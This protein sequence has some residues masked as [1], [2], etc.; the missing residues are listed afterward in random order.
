MQA[1]NFQLKKFY[2]FKSICLSFHCFYF[3]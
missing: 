1:I 3:I 2:I